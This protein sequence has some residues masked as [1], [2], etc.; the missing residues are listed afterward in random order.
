MIK[1]G[2]IALGGALIFYISMVLL[3]TIFTIACVY[4]GL[5]LICKGIVNAFKQK[6]YKG[7][8][9]SRGSIASESVIQSKKL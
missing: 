1:H 2:F 6:S 4:G 3:A 7:C 9:Y 5:T 8:G